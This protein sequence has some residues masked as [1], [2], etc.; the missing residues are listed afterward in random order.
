MTAANFVPGGQRPCKHLRSKEMYYAAAPYEEDE[1]SSGIYWCLHTQ[2][3]IGP[4]GHAV[5]CEECTPGR[6]CYTRLG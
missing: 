6:P 4:D 5:D 1:F 3:A 2:D